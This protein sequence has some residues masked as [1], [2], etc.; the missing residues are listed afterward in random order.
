MGRERD[1]MPPSVTLRAATPDDEPFLFTLYKTTRALEMSLVD[2]DEAQKETFVRRQF[3]A[4][5]HHYHTHFPNARHDIIEEDGRPIGRLYVNRTPDEIR[6]MDIILLPERRS[7]G[8]GRQLVTPLLHEAETTGRPVRL[9]VWQLNDGAQ[10]FYR[11][12][13]FVD[14]GEAGAYRSM[15]YHPPAREPEEET[16]PIEST[17]HIMPQAPTKIEQGVKK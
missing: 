3:E 1:S 11:R 6:L 4:Q 7:S 10:R 14:S 12:L 15:T 2:W 17:A 13:G 8:L 9:Y 5:Q 16:S